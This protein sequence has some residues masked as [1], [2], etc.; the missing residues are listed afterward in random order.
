MEEYKWAVKQNKCLSGTGC[1][2]TT[3]QM[4]ISGPESKVMI[5]IETT[6]PTPAATF[7]C[8]GNPVEQGAT[9]AVPTITFVGP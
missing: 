7:A 9:Y 1:S 3:L 5:M 6:V 2:L 4:D 8:T